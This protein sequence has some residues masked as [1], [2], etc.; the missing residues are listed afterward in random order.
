MD[1][2]EC[3]QFLASMPPDTDFDLI[4]SGNLSRMPMILMSSTF[5]DE[6]TRASYVR[7]LPQ[8]IRKSLDEIPLSVKEKLEG[9]TRI[10]H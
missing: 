7:M 1:V 9:K 10:F 8:R 5:E 4:H 6:A 2:A 3:R